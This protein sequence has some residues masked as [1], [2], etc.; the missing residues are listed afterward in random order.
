[1]GSPARVQWQETRFLKE[2]SFLAGL[3]VQWQGTLPRL[4]YWARKIVRRSRRRHSE[5]ALSRD[6]NSKWEAMALLIS[7]KTCARFGEAEGP[8]GSGTFS[9]ALNTF[10]R[11]SQLVVSLILPQQL[12]QNPGF[13]PSVSADSRGCRN[14]NSRILCCQW[15][16]S[17]ENRPTLTA[18]PQYRSKQLLILNLEAL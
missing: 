16:E 4:P 11:D 6:A 3:V 15:R 10:L 7:S 12:R 13:S 14:L 8:L 18:G 1:M 5:L 17:G 9:G 2:S